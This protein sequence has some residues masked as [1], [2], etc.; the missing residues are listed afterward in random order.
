VP[1]ASRLVK[2]QNPSRLYAAAAALARFCALLILP[3]S[4]TLAQQPSNLPPDT[5]SA[6]QQRVAS[7]GADVGIVLLRLDGSLTWSLNG[8]EP[9]H[10]ASTMKIPVMMEL[11]H[12]AHDGKLKLDDLLLVKNEF[13][14]IA[15]GSTYHLNPGDDSEKELYKAE[16]QRRSL[17]QLCVLMITVSSN[18]ATNLLIEKLGVDNIRATIHDFH[19][20]GM[21]VVRGV[22][23]QKAFD[24][25]LNNTTTARGLAALL[26]ALAKEQAFNASA[27]RE[28]VAILQQQTFNEGIPAGLPAGTRVAHKTGEITRIHHDAAI[29]YAPKPFVL[30]ILVRGINNFQQSSVLIADLTRLL[31]PATQ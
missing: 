23:D 13:H 11:F 3:A 24:K 15:D 2:Q 25:G 20:D 28:M 4:A 1:I 8:D 19:A 9:F 30:V 26:E 16:G 6:V 29:V 7:S 12:Q 5:T 31:Y 21:S 18:L 27:S 10:A 17:K 22:E 14:S